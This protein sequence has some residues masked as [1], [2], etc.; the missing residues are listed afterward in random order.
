MTIRIGRRELITA[1]GGTAV[2]WPLAAQRL[3]GAR[4]LMGHDFWSS[5]VERNRKVLDYFL[6]Q[7]HLEGLSLRRVAVGELFHPA[8]YETF[9]L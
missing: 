4:A 2:A 6:A 3:A 8:T 1:L 5:G 7:H 9:M